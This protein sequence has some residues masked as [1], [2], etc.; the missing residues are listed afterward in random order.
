[1]VGELETTVIPLTEGETF[2]R[3]LLFSNGVV[4]DFDEIMKKDRSVKSRV[5]HDSASY[6]L[7]HIHTSIFVAASPLCSNDLIKSEKSSSCW[8]KSFSQS[9]VKQ[10]NT[11]S[12]K[13]SEKEAMELLLP[14]NVHTLVAK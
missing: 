13:L 10:A 7:S 3:L 2:S 6:H 14:L 9:M 1:M 4:T 8:R 11:R 5:V 12:K